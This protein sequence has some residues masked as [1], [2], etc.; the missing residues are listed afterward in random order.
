MTRRTLGLSATIALVASGCSDAHVSGPERAAYLTLMGQDTLAVEWIE[1]GEGY[2]DAQ[3]LLR[4]TRTTF[5][6]YHLEM[7]DAG[8]LM[9]YSARTYAGGSNAG[10]LLRSETLV[11]DGAGRAMVTTQ[12]GEE[13][14]R[15][16]DAPTGSVPFVD[17]L[18][19]PFEAALRWQV[20]QGSIGD[21]VSTFSGRG[22]SFAL[23]QNGSGSW[24]LRHP[25]RGVSTV[26]LDEEG[27]ILALDG[28]GS[29]RAYDLTRHAWDEL[30][31]PAMGTAFAD[32]PLGDLSGRG[33]IRAE[34]AGIAFA[35][36]Y[37]APQK[38]GRTIFGEL[39]TYGVWW[40]TGA[41]N[42]T[43][44]SFDGDIT[45]D[46]VVIP[47]GD[48]SL[49]SIPDADGGTLIISR[50]T[51]QGGQSYDEAE[52]QARVRLRRDALDETVEVFEI[53]VVAADDG[54]R[55]ELR[56]DDVVYWVP[57]TVN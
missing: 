56:W 39:L 33:L 3:A 35:G 19:W 40:R 4:G 17:I 6:E 20:R 16:F 22:M 2:V 49:T 38:R 42:A 51:G 7:S 47:A 12:G 32:R 37:G 34:I 46:G 52:D 11:S 45:I 13:Q 29:T 50:R 31:M 36:D 5:G 10:E 14:R 57:F 21:A 27:R 24:G 9:A 43:Q 1:F 8:E 25:S 26:Q 28:T 18:H 55:I 30:D 48:Y 54:G 44:F 53:R 23:T 15:D 41:N